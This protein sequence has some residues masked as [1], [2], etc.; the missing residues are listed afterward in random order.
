MKEVDS[1]INGFQVQG[2][3]Q[4]GLQNKYQCQALELRHLQVGK[5]RGQQRGR[6]M[7]A[8]VSAILSY[9]GIPNAK[10]VLQD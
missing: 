3:G 4:L 6:N 7:A 1:L 5:K 9:N 8:G 2:N 10:L